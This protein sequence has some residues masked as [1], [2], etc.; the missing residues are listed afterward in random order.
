MAEKEILGIARVLNTKHGKWDA[1]WVV[2]RIIFICAL[3]LF[4][5]GFI[6]FLLLLFLC[7]VDPFLFISVVIGYIGLRLRQITAK[8]RPAFF[9]WRSF[10]YTSVS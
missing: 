4:V 10:F 8:R 5:V 7:M 2:Y 1:G 3:F 9:L 6:L